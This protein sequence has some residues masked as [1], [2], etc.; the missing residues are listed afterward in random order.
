MAAGR[1][2]FVHELCRAP[3]RILDAA[4]CV[5]YV[6]IAQHGRKTVGADEQSIARFNIDLV[7]VG[8]QVLVAAQRTRDDRPV[9]MC[10]RLFRGELARFDHVGHEAVIARELLQGALVQQVGTRIPYLGDNQALAFEHGSRHRRAHALAAAS[11]ARRLDDGAIRI[12]D[13]AGELLAVRMLRSAFGQ[14][15]DG[16]FGCHLAGRMAA[17]AVGDDEQRRCDDKAVLIVIAQAADVG[18]AAECGDGSAA[19]ARRGLV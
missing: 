7:D 13:C 5:L 10:P 16:D 11:F 17:H 18:S 9:R 19:R 8:V 4:E 15:V 1:D 2:G 6:R 12:L 3:L 14:H